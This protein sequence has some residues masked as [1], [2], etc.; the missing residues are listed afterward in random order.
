LLD[1]DDL[2]HRKNA[3]K[4]LGLNPRDPAVLIQ[5]G[6][7]SNRDVLGLL[8]R[9]IPL[10]NR[11]PR[12]QIAIAEWAIS[13]DPMQMW[14]GTVLVRGFPIS[15]YFRAFDLTIA[16]AGYNSF[17][18]II[19]FAVPAIFMANTHRSMDAQATR[20]D[21]AEEHG[22][23]MTLDP[24]KLGQLSHIVPVLLNAKAREFLEG[25]CRRLAQ[26]NG[27]AEAAAI[28]ESMM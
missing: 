18:E 22:A 27:A 5:L 7:G 9:I 4:A 2:L 16:A 1:E 17:N 12:L 11:I 13:T 15:Q 24:S 20:A 26:P 21:F 6:S 23:A 3:A 25:N 8:D 28:L 19:S 14:P 10:L